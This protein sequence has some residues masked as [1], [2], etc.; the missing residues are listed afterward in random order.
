MPPM[1]KLASIL[2]LSLLAACSSSIDRSDQLRDAKLV[3]GISTK[4][5][6]VNMIGLPA[7]IDRDE[8]KKLEIWQ[9]TGKPL[10]S[11]F[12]V[13][14]PILNVGDIYGITTRSSIGNQPVTLI[15]VFDEA[16]RL[17]NIYKPTQGENK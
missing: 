5:D 10:S 8:A 14:L 12:F 13:P 6:V 7:K 2:F 4:S 15:C 17:L 3:A 11:S 9:Y 1:T 16:G